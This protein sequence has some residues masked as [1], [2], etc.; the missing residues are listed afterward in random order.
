MSYFSSVSGF[1]VGVGFGF[2]VPSSVRF[3][4]VTASS[5]ASTI[6]ALL[7]DDCVPLLL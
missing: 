3:M 6:V 5:S 4:P 1:G 7:F 2:A